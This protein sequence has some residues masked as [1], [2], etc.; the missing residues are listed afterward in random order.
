MP[1][2]PTA[3]I[4]IF[5]VDGSHVDVLET[6][7]Q[8]AA[9]ASTCPPAPTIFNGICPFTYPQGAKLYVNVQNVA[10]VESL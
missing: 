7:E 10:R 5:L 1:P 2:P 4:R 3:H 9:L 6:L 8:F